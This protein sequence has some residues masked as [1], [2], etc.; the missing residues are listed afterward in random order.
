MERLTLPNS[1]RKGQSR[2]PHMRFVQSFYYALPQSHVL[3]GDA[4]VCQ[5]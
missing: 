1:H 4:R 3:L 2:D 5:K